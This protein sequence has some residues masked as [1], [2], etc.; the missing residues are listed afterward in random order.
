MNYEDW[1]PRRNQSRATKTAIRRFRRMVLHGI[2]P[3]K[4]AHW[5]TTVAPGVAHALLTMEEIRKLSSQVTF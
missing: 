3:T 1:R 4:P 5:L 2:D